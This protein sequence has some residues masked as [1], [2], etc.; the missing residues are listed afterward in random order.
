MSHKIAKLARKQL[1]SVTD[2]T[3]ELV[4]T[5]KR[6]VTSK[7]GKRSWTTVTLSHRLGTYK[8]RLN[9]LKSKLQKGG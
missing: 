6:I 9:A 2:R 8:Q 7:D 3:V 4:A 1:K 5:N